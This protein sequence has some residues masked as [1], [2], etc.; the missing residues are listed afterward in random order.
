VEAAKTETRAD[1]D[2]VKRSEAGRADIAIKTHLWGKDYKKLDVYG[3]KSTYAHIA[4]GQFTSFHDKFFLPL[5][6]M[7]VI[8]GTFNETEVI[9]KMQKA[10]DDFRT[11]EFNPELI[12]RVIEFKPIINTVQLVSRSKGPAQATIT[13][14]NPGAR[15]D[16]S[17]T[18]CAYMLSALINDKNGRIAKTMNTRGIKD[19]TASFDCHNFE[20]TLTISATVTDSNYNSAF[21]RIDSMIE[22]FKKKDYF[23]TEELLATNKTV[24]DEFNNLRHHT[25]AFMMLVAKY[26]YSN[27]ENYFPSLSDSIQGVTVPMMQQYMK[28][29]FE[30][31]AGVKCLY[32]DTSALAAAPAGQRYYALD[33][34][35]KEIKFTYPQNV[36]DVD[37][38]TG[39]A[40]LERLIQWLRI[41]PDMHIQINGFA[42]KSEFTKSY[43][44]TVTKFIKNT[45]TFRK[46]MPDAIKVGYLRL[47]LMRA[48][49]IAKAIYEAGITED[50]ISGTSMVFTSDSDE[51]AAN[52][53][54]CTVTMEKIQPRVSLYEYHFG[55]KKEGEQPQTVPAQINRDR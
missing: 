18:Y 53:R 50:R 51:G 5:N 28:D 52:N 37:T 26:R 4:T 54:K 38:V 10:F 30:G 20:G 17:A 21:S 9:N 33:E 15:Q 14:Q 23:T 29:Y 24:S 7:V 35:I 12:R 41:N 44:T 45:P 36:A 46:A 55:K 3:D 34:S 47:E 8:T 48:M 32:A 25:H 27:D 13:Y 1:L 19:L 31:R 2:S 16:R 40:D 49:K 39:T 11:K 42:D 22:G 43:D 6:S